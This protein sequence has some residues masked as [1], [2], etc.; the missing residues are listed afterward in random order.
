VSLK[1]GKKT[2]ALGFRTARYVYIEKA[3]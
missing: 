3:V 2:V 1:L